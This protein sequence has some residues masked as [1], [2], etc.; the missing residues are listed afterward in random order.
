[1]RLTLDGRRLVDQILQ[2]VGGIT[3]SLQP[4][5]T[6]GVAPPRVLSVAGGTAR[7]TFGCAEVVARAG[8]RAEMWVAPSGVRLRVVAA[9]APTEIRAARFGDGTTRPPLGTA[10]THGKVDVISVPDALRTPAWRVRLATS[11]RALACNVG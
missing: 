11:G 7:L 10:S 5:G 4:R 8:G 2:Q 9:T 6:V 3:L 1:V